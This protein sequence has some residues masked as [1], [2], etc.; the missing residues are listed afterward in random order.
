MFNRL[1]TSVFGS[2]NE[3]LLRQLNGIVRK[4]NALESQMAALS[5]EQL[6]A[7]TPEFQQRIANGESLDKLL[8]EAFAVCREASKRV[9]GMRHYD[10]QLIGGMVL[11]M[12]KI[13]EMRT[14][15]G[16]TLVATLPTYLN[17]LAG[18]GVHVV[19]VND[20]LARRDAGWMGKLYTW[21]GLTVGVVYPGMPHSDK[22]AAYAADITYATNNEIGFD[23]LRDNMK[24]QLA[25]M[26]QRPFNYAI[27]D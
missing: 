16:K 7:K 24:Y 27:V 20:Y 26:V 23:Y 1:L 21:L 11:H 15:E 25:A 3:R 4:V 2:R 19:T 5:D 18:K 22:H 8:P 17:A 14:G 13:A 12:G 6:Q 10:V 9:L